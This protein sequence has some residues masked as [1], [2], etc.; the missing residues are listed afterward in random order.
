MADE[1]QLDVRSL[2]ITQRFST[3]FAKLED[4][5]PGESLLLINDFEPV[6]LYA[7]LD[8]RGYTY[9]SRQVSDVEWHIRITKR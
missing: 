5:P 3:I 8:N 7:A 6:P 9:V 2:D 1:Q 4:L